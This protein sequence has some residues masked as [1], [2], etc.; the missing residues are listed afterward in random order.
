MFRTSIAGAARGTASLGLMMRATNST[1]SFVP[2]CSAK[3][4]AASRLSGNHSC[5][6]CWNSCPALGMCSSST[7]YVAL[8]LLPLLPTLALSFPSSSS[9]LNLLPNRSQWSPVLPRSLELS[10]KPFSLSHRC[11]SSQGPFGRPIC[12]KSPLVC[13]MCTEPVPSA[14]V[15]RCSRPSRLYAGDVRGIA[16]TSPQMRRPSCGD[17]LAFL[18]RGDAAASTSLLEPMRLIEGNDANLLTQLPMEPSS[19]RKIKV[20]TLSG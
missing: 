16:E 2:M 5:A 15:K 14:A 19:P 8:S 10:S 12:S 20:F 7:M 1:R 6:H 11:Q 3:R 18:P 13:S 9:A 4:I 17:A